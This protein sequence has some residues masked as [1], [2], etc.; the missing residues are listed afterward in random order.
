MVL[1]STKEIL[2]WP[3]LL[4]F[5]AAFPFISLEGGDYVL[6]F[7]AEKGFSSELEGKLALGGN[8]L[9]DMVDAGPLMKIDK[10]ASHVPPCFFIN[11]YSDIF[12][13]P[14]LIE[15]LLHGLIG[16][17]SGDSFHV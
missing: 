1:P 9:K 13:R 5:L 14:V 8:I 7:L 15:G 4:F 2:L 3:W 11:A 16:E 17:G 6:C 10:G 12:Y